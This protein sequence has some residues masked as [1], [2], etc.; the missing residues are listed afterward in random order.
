MLSLVY[1][2]WYYSGAFFSIKDKIKFVAFEVFESITAFEDI[3][4]GRDVTSCRAL[5]LEAYGIV[6]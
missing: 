2:F 6:Q 3:T 1:L 5:T 4:K